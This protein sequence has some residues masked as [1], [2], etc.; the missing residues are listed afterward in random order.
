MFLLI[1]ALALVA[2]G[3]LLRSTKDDVLQK[4]G[5]WCYGFAVIVALVVA[6]VSCAGPTSPTA[7]YRF[8]F[9]PAPGCEP[10]VLPKEPSQKPNLIVQERDGAP[11]FVIWNFSDGTKLQME[12]REVAGVFLVCK[13]L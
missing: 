7:V 9:E 2:L 3:A 8:T 6:N 10:G 4:C 1:F 13:I 5:Y 11:V 12:F